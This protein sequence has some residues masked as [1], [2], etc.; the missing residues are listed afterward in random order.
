MRKFNAR[1]LVLS[2]VA[3]LA[4]GFILTGCMGEVEED[5][6]E[7]DVPEMEQPVFEEEEP[8]FEE[9]VDEP[10][11]MEEDTTEEEPMY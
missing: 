6:T 5:E 7:N 4:S 11:E 2:L 8:I 1:L 9:D 10:V 3:L